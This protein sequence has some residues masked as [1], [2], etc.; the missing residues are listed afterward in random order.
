MQEVNAAPRPMPVV[1]AIGTALMRETLREAV[2]NLP[3]LRFAGE[4]GNWD[5]LRP[6]LRQSEPWI[7]VLSTT[8]SG[9]IPDDIAALMREHETRPRLMLL[10]RT[11]VTPPQA[12]LYRSL[13]PRAI[14]TTDM[15]TSE[16]LWIL[17][18][19][20]RDMTVLPSMEPQEEEA[21]PPAAHGA[22]HAADLSL[23]ERELL[24]LLAG[25]LSEKEIAER[26]G[27]A[28]RTI[29]TYLDR[30]RAKL[31]ATN[32]VHAVALAVAQGR[33]TATRSR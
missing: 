26:M 31:G 23:R 30:I 9:F 19:L 24:Q 12:A 2:G 5:E 3:G 8:I 25:G 18:L 16:Y 22:G 6:L 14:V 32:R 7:L 27:I 4:A 33:V 11:D 20:Q 21:A 28:L 17:Q 10:V 1:F 15:R 29:H 13:K